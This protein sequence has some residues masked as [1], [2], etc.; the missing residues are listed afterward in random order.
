MAELYAKQSKWDYPNYVEYAHNSEVQPFEFYLIKGKKQTVSQSLIYKQKVAYQPQIKTKVEAGWL[1]LSTS[2]V[3]V[4]FTVA[5]AISHRFFAKSLGT[6]VTYQAAAARYRE[7]NIF[8]IQATFFAKA[9]A[10][11]AIALFFVTITQQYGFM[12]FELKG[13]FLL[14]FFTALFTALV[15]LRFVFFRFIGLYTENET[16]RILN[17]TAD[18]FFILLGLLTFFIFLLTRFGP[19]FFS[20]TSLIIIGIVLVV[21]EIFKIA[22]YGQIFLE[23]HISFLFLILYLC[24]LEIFPFLV[25]LKAFNFF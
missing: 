22:R 21:Y 24:A 17:F 6:I 19:S 16:S 8:Y 4:L 18:Q 7:R 15:I 13:Y 20:S 5:V 10:V 25:L 2:F 11:M 1:L 12:L 9:A 3:L 23:K 14:F